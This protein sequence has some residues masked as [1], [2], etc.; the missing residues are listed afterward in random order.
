MDVL[1][2]TRIQ[3]PT[4]AVDGV[5][6]EYSCLVCENQG[7]PQE[8]CVNSKIPIEGERMYNSTAYDFIL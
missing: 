2:V 5:T 1:N 6:G 3:L 4:L 7:T 8:V